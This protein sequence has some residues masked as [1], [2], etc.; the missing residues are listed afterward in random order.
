MES[1]AMDIEKGSIND[2]QDAPVGQPTVG[3]RIGRWNR[4]FPRL[5]RLLWIATGLAVLALL[6]WV[7]YPKPQVRQ[8]FNM[9]PQVVGVAAAADTSIDITL[10]ALGTV[11]PLATAIV[12]PQV[13]GLLTKLYFQEGQ[14]VNAG[15][16]LAQIDPRPFQATLDQ[17][18]G[19]LAKDEANLAN[20]RADLARYQPLAKQHSISAQQLAAQQALVRSDSGLVEADRAAIENATINLGYT[21]IVS[22]VS[23]RVGLHLVD[24]GNMVQAGQGTGIV[25]V[26]E[27][28]PM[29]VVFSVPQDDVSRIMARFSQGAVLRADAWD[30]NQTGLLASGKLDAID[31][32]VDQS[33][34]T[35]KMRAI[36][37]NTDNRLF[38]GQFVNIR[39]LVDTLQHQ[40]VVPMSAIQH[41]PEGDFVFVI[42]SD[43]TVS[44]QKVALGARQ[45][46]KVAVAKGLQPGTRVVI[47]GADRLRDG[48]AAA[49]AGNTPPPVVSQQDSRAKIR[50]EIEQACGADFAKLCNGETGRGRMMCLFQH[51]DSLS[52]GCRTTLETLRRER[53][54][55]P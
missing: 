12:K 14:M 28:S 17:A 45:E 22:P 18:R 46:D 33:T 38:P 25:V 24:V 16:P 9:G 40:T 43:Q 27:L 47:D 48:S 31:N 20:A 15:D 32:V 41:G 26:T 54:S 30:R 34:G 35:V 37:P 2:D 4:N 1:P 6:I 36:F 7:F 50:S 52:E 42:N 5:S 29:S 44:G 23:G 21:R 39:L 8:R 51:R 55:A 13:S 19:Q 11:T 3:G 53:R 10:N 49:I